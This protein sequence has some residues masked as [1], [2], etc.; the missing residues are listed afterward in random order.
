VANPQEKKEFL[1]MIALNFVGDGVSLTP[2]WKEPFHWL[3]EGLLLDDGGP[4]RT[5]FELKNWLRTS[6]AEALD[7]V[8]RGVA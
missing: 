1:E 8:L 6:D 5:A 7:R 2:T 4:S 3:A